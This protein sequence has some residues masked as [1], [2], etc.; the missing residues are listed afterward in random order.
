M[1]MVSGQTPSVPRKG[2][3]MMGG[4]KTVLRR[5]R[6]GAAARLVM[7]FPLVKGEDTG[8]ATKRA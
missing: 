3:S 2:G 7:L 5:R 1:A 6:K 4:V 8:Y